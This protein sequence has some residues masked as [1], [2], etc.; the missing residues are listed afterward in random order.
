M[1]NTIKNKETACELDIDAAKQRLKD[2]IKQFKEA[3]TDIN[4]KPRVRPREY[5]FLAPYAIV[6]YGLA[7][8]IDVLIDHSRE[9]NLEGL[10]RMFLECYAEFVELASVYNDPVKIQKEIN[11][12][13]SREI[14]RQM[15]ILENANKSSSIPDKNV[16]VEEMKSHI[17]SL[18]SSAFPSKASSIEKN[19]SAEDFMKSVNEMKNEIAADPNMI[20][21]KRVKMAKSGGGSDFI[22]HA[23]NANPVWGPDG[24]YGVEIV[25]GIL[26]ESVHGNLYSVFYRAQNGEELSFDFKASGLIAIIEIVQKSLDFMKDKLNSLV[27]SKKE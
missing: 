27:S 4:S 12:L 2:S 14:K 6:S 25:Y 23:L 17:F 22:K 18:I 15:T 3:F 7:Y 10:L 20:D 26:S 5:A 21:P 8:D 16:F 13:F 24:Y 19:S 1:E 9:A 11:Y